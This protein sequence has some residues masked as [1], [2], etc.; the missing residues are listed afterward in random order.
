MK[1]LIKSEQEL[2]DSEIK[3]ERIATRFSNSG[4]VIVPKEFVGRKIILLV[5][6]KISK[7][8]QK[9]RKTQKAKKLRIRI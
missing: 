4:H 3:L 2:I 9:P 8:K 6:K 5:V 1:V 7:I